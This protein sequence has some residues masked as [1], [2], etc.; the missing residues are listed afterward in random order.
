MELIKYLPKKNNLNDLSEL[1]KTVTDFLRI[2]ENSKIN[3]NEKHRLNLLTLRLID[4]INNVRR[5]KI[6]WI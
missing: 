6:E 3:D 2:I 4:I 5:Q 1:L